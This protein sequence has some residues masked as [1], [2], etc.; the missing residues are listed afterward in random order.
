MCNKKS[1]SNVAALKR[2]MSGFGVGKTPFLFLRLTWI[3]NFFKRIYY[4]HIVIAQK[5]L[6]VY[7]THNPQDF[8][9]GTEPHEMC[10]R[11]DYSVADGLRGWADIVNRVSCGYVGV[12]FHQ[13][14][15]PIEE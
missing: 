10:E 12:V 8:F 3:G 4:G 15:E 7:F 13:G 1:R 9:D 11:I 14:G 2:H 6:C 5:D